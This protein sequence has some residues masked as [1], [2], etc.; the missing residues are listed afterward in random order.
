MLNVNNQISF[1]GIKGTI[2]RKNG[3]EEKLEEINPELME[4]GS[5]LN[6]KNISKEVSEA[7]KGYSDIKSIKFLS[8]DKGSRVILDNTSEETEDIEFKNVKNGSIILEGNSR[9]KIT[10]KAQDCQIYIGDNSKL[11]IEESVDNKI[12]QRGGTL[13]IKNLSSEY[14]IPEYDRN[15]KI[16]RYPYTKPVDDET[17]KREGLERV[18]R[19]IKEAQEEVVKDRDFARGRLR[20]YLSSYS[21]VVISG[22]STTNIKNANNG[23][24]IHHF[25][26]DSNL[27]IENLNE[28]SK[29]IAPARYSDVFYDTK[30]L[31]SSLSETELKDS[32]RELC[33]L[34]ARHTLRKMN[35]AEANDLIER[36]LNMKLN[37]YGKNE[38][39]DIV[40]NISISQ[41]DAEVII[42]FNRLNPDDFNIG[43][44]SKEA[45]SYRTKHVENNNGGEILSNLKL[46][47][48]TVGNMYDDKRENVDSQYF[49]Y[50]GKRDAVKEDA[51]NLEPYTN[52]RDFKN[53]YGQNY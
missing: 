34:E 52:R 48:I 36:M 39:K 33:R 4:N 12:S 15:H 25:S 18:E 17:V 53:R 41:E 51:Y 7:L 13:D 9:A 30:K 38:E 32:L 43:M 49:D 14:P 19:T 23:T 42:D 6:I 11:S 35:P 47:R 5:T 8:V 2:T 3:T 46:T 50:R 40:R 24:I 21:S 10:G 16:N 20:E 28:G 26:E 44:T 29:L 22:N 1:H 45:E 37:S 31:L 27:N